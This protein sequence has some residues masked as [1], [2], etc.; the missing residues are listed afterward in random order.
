MCILVITA[1]TR[2][3]NRQNN[4]NILTNQKL[5]QTAVV[6]QQKKQQTTLFLLIFL[7]CI[8]SSSNTDF[9]SLDIS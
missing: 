2:L 3:T 9:I 8:N 4:L 5:E 1:S 7:Y 6:I